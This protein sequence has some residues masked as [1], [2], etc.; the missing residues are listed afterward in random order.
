MSDGG[1]RRRRREEV[2]LL[3]LLVIMAMVVMAINGGE[4]EVKWRAGRRNGRS[5]VVGG[6]RLARRYV[7]HLPFVAMSALSAGERTPA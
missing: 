2:L 6:R 4:V 3:L 5:S 7:S 1:R